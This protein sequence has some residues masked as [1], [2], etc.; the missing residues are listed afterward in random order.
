MVLLASVYIGQVLL[1]GLK[2]LGR[3]I[4]EHRL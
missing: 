2:M 4:F 3:D 1:L